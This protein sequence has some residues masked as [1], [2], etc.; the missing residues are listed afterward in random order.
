MASTR[1][2]FSGMRR[3]RVA[4]TLAVLAALGAFWAVT[5]PHLPAAERGRR[6]AERHGCFG[7]H[8][9]GGLHGAANPG[10]ADRTVPGFEGDL[11]MYAKTPDEVL[12]WIRDG[13]NVKRAESKSWRAARAAGA[14]RMPAYGKRL[15]RQELADLTAFVL[16]VSGSPEPTDSLAR[17]GRSRV[18]SL[19]CTGCHGAGGRLALRNPGSL[20]G[21][22]PSWDGRD[23]PELVADRAEFGEWVEHGV[24]R[25][26]KANAAARF[27]LR[28]A[29]VRM[30]AYERFVAPG[31]VDAMWAYVG[32]LRSLPH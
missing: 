29:D 2:V 17:A 32:W 30:P 15:R 8:G 18:D 25:R 22:I 1:V 5:L 16:A 10:R 24:S 23:F 21:Y 7:C 3:L 27:F 4:L 12:E 28:R 14:L 20:K 26:L 13:V 31:D 19:G 11:M 6:L 9:P